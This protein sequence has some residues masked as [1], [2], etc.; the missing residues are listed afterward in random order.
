MQASAQKRAR[1][2]DAEEDQP[3]LSLVSARY[4]STVALL[5]MSSHSRA[6]DPWTSRTLRFPFPTSPWPKYLHLLSVVPLA[7]AG[8]RPGYE[9]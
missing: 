2:E 1:V 6:Q 3:Q 7:Q 5:T 8:P 9:M 4:S